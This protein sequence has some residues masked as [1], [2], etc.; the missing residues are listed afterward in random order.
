MSLFRA[1]LW[2]LAIF[3]LNACAVFQKDKGETVEVSEEIYEEPMEVEVSG[4]YRKSPTID[5]RLIHTRL[6]VSPIWKKAYLS[7]EAYL[8]LTPHFY[9]MDSLVL[10]AKSF[11][12]LEV[13]RLYG[14]DS[15]QDLTYAYDNLAI[16]VYF[17]EK[18][19]QKDTLEIYIRYTAKPNEM[20]AGGSAAITSDK[21]L[22][23]INHDL[24][25]PDKPQQIWTQGETHGS[26]KWFPTIDQP[27]QKTSQEIY[28]TV[29]DKFKTLSNGSFEYSILNEDGTRTDYWKQS[30]PHAPYLFMMAIGEFAIVEDTWRDSIPVN[31]W[32]EPEYEKHARMIFGNTP[33]MME[34]F[35]NIFNYDYPWDKY[36]Q[37]VVRDFV[38]GAMENTSATIHYEKVQHDERE[39]LDETYESLIAHELV[40][41][42]FG[43]V[44]TCESWSNLALNES[45]ATYGEYLWEEHKY[46]KMAA[47][48]M[49]DQKAASYFDEAR[50]KQ[51]P[52]FQFYYEEPEDLFDR[53]RYQKGGVLLHL[54]RK[55][56]GDEAFF[57]SLSY[58]L[59][60]RS[61]KA[62]ENHHLRLA[63]EEVTGR[64]M[65]WFFNQWFNEAGHL[66]LDVSYNYNEFNQDLDISLRQKQDFEEGTLYRM[67]VEVAV[68]YAD[69]SVEKHEVY[70]EGIEQT[71]SIE[72]REKP[73]GVDFDVE[74][75]L[76]A[77][78]TESKEV[79]AWLAQYHFNE[80]YRAK[81]QAILAVVDSLSEVE[82][83][84]QVAFL[85]QIL[86]EDFHGL[87]QAGLKY[88]LPEMKSSLQQK[89][90]SEV[91]HLAL[92]DPEASV[93]AEA[94][95]AL[96]KTKP[97]EDVKD[98]LEKGLED[99]AYSVISAALWAYEKN[100]PK[101][102]LAVAKAFEDV[103]QVRIQTRMIN[104]YANYGG[105][106][107]AA[108]FKS[109][110]RKLP[111]NY[112]FSVLLNY[113]DFLN[114]QSPDVVSKELK[115]LET[116]YKES[117]ETWHKMVISR[118]YANVYE[119]FNA[120]LKKQKL[121]EK[122]GEKLTAQ[123]RQLKELVEQ[124][125]DT[126]DQIEHDIR[127]SF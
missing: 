22:Y 92:N 86:S 47:D 84:L 21:G 6:E 78:V 48:Y 82:A 94:F 104:I 62:A 9:D 116:A 19:S 85:E 14:E 24:S 61:F 91:K 31:Y 120:D 67:P 46:G 37:V 53:H 56:V 96:A 25:D 8:T 112:R 111:E 33:E 16:T 66:E 90:E 109:M 126:V 95:H 105:P 23:F 52:I 125:S 58:Y 76:L 7:G 36:D 127:T 123:E 117:T 60:E 20:E 97:A 44:V 100:Y 93:R 102:I 27:N 35:S 3:S 115:L 2:I 121:H 64:D 87:K 13:A 73:I 110:Y 114:R 40:H 15:S 108:F 79:A 81:K 63:F 88:L 80:Q 29:E 65:N 28:I 55:T 51:E 119:H 4:T 107:Q 10:D 38:S 98:V 72:V 113:A 42:W 101:E 26:S 54:L 18:L 57:A 41:H 89:F 11:D 106:K 32:V 5:F 34:F 83:D 49:L 69:S 68:Y 39:H 30:L 103:D 118:V 43:N 124:L 71:I 50:F 77:E 12:I 45:F 75:V 59:N 74:K 1:F 122:E 17:D 70:M 99:S